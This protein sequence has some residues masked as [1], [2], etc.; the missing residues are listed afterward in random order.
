[1]RGF[2]DEMMALGVEGMTISPGYS[3]EKAPD[4]DHFLARRQTTD[5]FR[6]VLSRAKRAWRFNQTPLFLEFL[7]GQLRPGMH[8]LGQPVVQHLWLAAAVLPA[9]RRLLPIVPRADGN[10]RL[11]R[12]RPQERQPQM[13]RLHGP[14]R[15]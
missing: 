11:G 2:F 4:Q 15:L 3:Y 9:R 13:P 6:A 12:L 1:M 14:L 10:D 8:A 5:L 7:R